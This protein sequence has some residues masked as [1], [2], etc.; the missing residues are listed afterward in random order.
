MV[1]QMIAVSGYLS[2]ETART[3]G[4]KTGYI[5]QWER[6]GWVLYRAPTLEESIR[7]VHPARTALEWSPREQCRTWAFGPLEG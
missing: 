1:S 6:G 2:W 7:A 4:S 3:L 5:V